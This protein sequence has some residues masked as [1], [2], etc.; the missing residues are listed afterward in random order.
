LSFSK[1]LIRSCMLLTSIT[2]SLS[3]SLSIMCLLFV[4]SLLLPLAL[5]SS[6]AALLVN[7]QGAPECK[8]ESSEDWERV[9]ALSHRVYGP[10]IGFK[11]PALILM[12]LSPCVK[13][14]LTCT[15]FPGRILLMKPRT[16]PI[17]ASSHSSRFSRP[18]TWTTL[19]RTSLV[20]LQPP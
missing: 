19:P 17:A 2:L 5:F 4:P 13:L 20:S 3:L 9:E 15:R 12:S 8:P 14:N 1:C 7:R 11:F 6:S 16:E 10:R 18:M